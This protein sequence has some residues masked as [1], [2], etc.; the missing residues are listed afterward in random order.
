MFCA[1]I[2]RDDM[3]FDPRFASNRARMENFDEMERE[4]N[5]ALSTRTT[6]EWFAILEPANVGS[7]GKVNSIADLFHDPHVEARNMLVDIPQPYG[8]EQSLKLPNTPINL[9]E[10]P[11][12]VGKGMPG[13]GEDTGPGVAR[14]GRVRRI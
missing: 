2:E 14:V 8:T 7:I 11:A 3:A 4:L 10:T 6:E 12:T 5:S 9:S 1:L 13:H